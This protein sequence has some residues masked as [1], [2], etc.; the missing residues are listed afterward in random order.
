MITQQDLIQHFQRSG[1]DPFSWACHVAMLLTL[2]E[3]NG[4]GQEDILTQLLTRINW[5]EETIMVIMSYALHLLPAQRATAQTRP[6]CP[7]SDAGLGLPCLEDL[8]SRFAA[9]AARH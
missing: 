8:E 3:E 2:A 7:S 4:L 9:L 1:K 5:D 6:E